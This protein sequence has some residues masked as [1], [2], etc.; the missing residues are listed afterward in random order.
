M[1]I[2][3][4]TDYYKTSKFEM[5]TTYT[6]DPGPPKFRWLFLEPI[7]LA[8]I[9]HLGWPVIVGMLTQTAI[10]TIDL[11]MVGRLDD[12]VAV[13]GT[14]AIM[15]SVVLLWAYGGFLSAISV[16]TQALSARRFSEGDLKQA[17][18][19]VSNSVAVSVV[20][21]A[22]ISMIAIAMIE[23]T[24][25]L[26]SKSSEVQAIGS[27]YSRIRLLSL[28]SMALM[29][30]FKSFYDG[31]GSV[32][33]HMTIAI[34]MNLVNVIANYFLI[35][36]FNKGGIVIEALGVYGA[37]WGSV[38]SS[39]VG[40]LI[41]ILWALR[42]HDRARFSIFTFK[43]LNK[44]V[45]F[46]IARLSVWSGLATVVLMAG[47][48]LF[49][50]IVSSIDEIQGTGSVNAS[51]ASIITHVMMLVFMT[52]L[53]FGTSTAT[54]VSQ[55]IGA[56]NV[57]L[58]Q[59]YV[60]QCVL[61]AVYVM[62]AFGLFT[63][64]FPKPIL[65]LFLPPDIEGNHLK[66]MVIAAAIPSLQLSALLLSPTAA[67][68]LVLTQALYGAGETRYVLIVEFILHF[69][70]LVPLAWFLSIYL[71]MGIVGC[72]IAAI[73]YASCLMLATAIRFIQGKWKKLSL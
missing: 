30:S 3:P 52:C 19:V 69:F 33:V 66:D 12:T 26:L 65:T 62:T 24:M 61:L 71:K 8:R 32:R 37:A 23:P 18:V 73:T 36:G 13:P 48:G 55:S 72:W 40:L 59:R 45:A 58:A 44:R 51:A 60:W 29:A 43:N 9:V 6:K 28:P 38:I 11:L 63:F 50:Y 31:I 41:M 57:K 64:F 67:A 46:T 53:A 42:K 14:A 54:L 49:N 4:K 16:G 34:I 25:T 21:S 56:K 70:C 20:A 2:E 1:T 47:V 10:N 35:Y 5:V 22:V 27:A 17:G 7:L 15:A 68:G 39:Y